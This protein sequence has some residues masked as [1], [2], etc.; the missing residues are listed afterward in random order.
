[1]EVV[2][3][4]HPAR[5]N[6]DRQE[7]IA[8]GFFDGVHLGHQALLQQAK[9]IANDTGAIFSVMTFDPHPQEVLNE[10]KRLFITPLPEKIL[11]M[12]DLGVE[13][14]Y[15]VRFDH[16]FA[17]LEPDEF[18]EQ[19]IIGFHVS[20]VVVGFDFTFGKKAK[21]TVKDLKQA[22][23]Q[24]HFGLTVIPKKT[25]QGQKISSTLIR[26]LIRKGQIEE[27]PYCLGTHYRLKAVIE[28]GRDNSCSLQPLW[29][30][31]LP[32]SGSYLVEFIQ[33]EK[34]HLAQLDIFYQGTENRLLFSGDEPDWKGEWE[35]VFLNRLS[36]NQ[37]S[38][39][40]EEGKMGGR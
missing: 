38:S 13:K 7:V 12:R 27:I 22:A 2:I 11:K 39:M 16:N 5:V 19:Y 34:R 3:V 1:M 4:V 40:Y 14:L 9:T 20:H 10:E 36:E 35:V 29:N 25:Y 21:G 26:Q 31:I 37:R 18:I 15:I 24:G 33:K 32:E 17:S 23:D 8:M 28:R 6:H 30:F